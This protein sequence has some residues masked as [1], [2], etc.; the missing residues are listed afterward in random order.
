MRYV[1]YYRV[2]TERQGRSGLGLDAQRTGISLYMNGM[3]AEAE[4]TDV[5]SG[6]RKSL[7][8]R[9]QIYMAIDYCKRHGLPLVVYRLD[10][11][12]RDV[13][14][15]S[16]CLNN[17]VKLI[18]CD[19]PATNGD[20]TTNKMVLTIMMSISQYEAERGSSRTKDALASIKRSGRK[21]GNPREFKKDEYLSG[22]MSTAKK[23]WTDRKDA[24]Y[25]MVLEFKLMGIDDGT[26][27]EKLNR[28]YAGEYSK[29]KYQR[30]IK[31]GGLIYGNSIR[32]GHVSERGGNRGSG[33]LST[34]LP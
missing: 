24:A 25:K 17:N 11:L 32:A 2:S 15:L 21:L 33:N 16:Y 26:I 12:A 18:A 4:F 8:K 6:T 19:F 29:L 30:L 22:G 27:I 20:A 34:V 9:S 28:M 7:G 14:F 13:E 10:R 1:S 5:C 23:H 3:P 31:S